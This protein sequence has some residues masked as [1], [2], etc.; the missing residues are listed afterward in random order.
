MTSIPLHHPL[1]HFDS[2][3]AAGE[4]AAAR[5]HL[6]DLCGLQRSGGAAQRG[7]AAS[8]TGGVA[9]RVSA[10]GRA[11]AWRRLAAAAVSL[12]HFDDALDCYAVLGDAKREHQLR[13][14]MERAVGCLPPN[15]H[16]QCVM[17]RVEEGPLKS[18]SGMSCNSYVRRRAWRDSCRCL[19]K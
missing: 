10:A 15:A 11:D 13:E 4:V 7:S 5:H 16:A 17:T 18:S 2:L 3:L 14:V 12:R 1:L 19:H 8:P 6:Q 9:P